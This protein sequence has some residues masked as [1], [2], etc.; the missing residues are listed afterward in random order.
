MCGIGSNPSGHWSTELPRAYITDYIDDPMIEREV[1]GDEL[2]RELLPTTEVLLVWH[3]RIDAAY[4]D[5]LPRL[6]GVV[7]YGVGYDN[8]DIRYAHD[9]GIVVCNTPDYGTDEVSD[10][11]LA[12]VM[13]IARGIAR[14]DHLCRSYQTN[15]QEH[16]LP[17]IRRTSEQVLG[18][19]GAG[20]IGGSLLLKAAACRMQTLF[21]DPY[22]PRGHEKMLGARRADSLDELLQA[23]DIV[24]IHTPL[25]EETEGMVNGR[26]ISAMKNGASLVNTA[27][28]RIVEHPDVFYTPLR[29]HTLQCV[30]L[31]VLPNEPPVESKLLTAWRNREAWLDGRLLINPHTAYFSQEAYVEMR[32]KAAQNALRILRG[33]PPFNLVNLL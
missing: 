26:F 18:V 20:R 15:W 30:A 25:T 14:Y 16:T 27:R 32:R 33:Q 7:R 2:A 3:H 6:K 11:A 8:V 10:T 9:R 23:S 17:E 12:M 19:I 28:G 1:L 4:I 21:Y 31:D 5:A 29:D 24:S 13:N 22:K